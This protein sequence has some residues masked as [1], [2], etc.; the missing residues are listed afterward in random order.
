MNCRPNSPLKLL[1]A[2]VPVVAIA[3]A[4]ILHS[5]TSGSRYSSIL[6]DPPS[7]SQNHRR[8]RLVNL[9]KDPKTVIPRETQLVQNAD[10]PQFGVLLTCSDG[11]F[12]LWL[13]WLIFFERLKIPDLPVYLFAED[14][15]THARCVELQD[16]SR[17][18]EY[19]ADVTCLPWDFVFEK[20]EG[21]ESLEAFSYNEMGYKLMMT[22]RPTVVKRL[23]K[24]FGRHI[25]FSDV[26]VVWLKNPITHIQQ[27]FMNI[28]PIVHILGQFDKKR[29]CPGFT[30]Y[31][32]CPEVIKF[33][34]MWQDDLSKGDPSKNQVPFN[35]VLDVAMSSGIPVPDHNGNTTVKKITAAFLP[36]ELFPN[37]KVYF[38]KMTDAEREGALVVHN[39]YIIGYDE[40]I[41]RF[42]NFDLWAL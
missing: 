38:E 19:R 31:R 39:N 9:I 37:G 10:T 34:D 41:D 26:D 24:E 33:I 7:A 6:R 40:K 35:N 4:C 23:L 12:D 22:H 25:I 20:K 17:E 27:V 16:Q 14:D 21:S 1:L 11:F 30:V 36:N 2:A 18:S 15:V 3:V 29:I 8:L 42:K 13:N 32:A 5:S 28:D